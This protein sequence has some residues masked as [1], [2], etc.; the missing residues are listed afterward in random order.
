MKKLLLTF[1]FV[2]LI[3]AVGVS[4]TLGVDN[5]LATAEENTPYTVNYI[6][7]EEDFMDFIK[8]GRYTANKYILTSDIYL[9]RLYAEGGKLGTTASG[10]DLL[11]FEGNFDGRGHAIVGLKEPLFDT[12]GEEGV[13]NDLLLIGVE[14][15][16]GS[17]LSTNP[18]YALAYLNKGTIKYVHMTG[19]V[20]YSA[21]VGT[22]NGTI[23]NSLAVIKRTNMVA[24]KE[25]ML[26]AYE[27][28]GTID[29][30]YSYAYDVSNDKEWG[31]RSYFI[32]AGLVD[33]VVINQALVCDE[34]IMLNDGVNLFNTPFVVPETMNNA[35]IGNKLAGYI[36]TTF[37]ICYYNADYLPYE[38]NIPYNLYD[39]NNG[40]YNTPGTF[41]GDGTKENPYEIGTIDGL[42]TL[43][44]LNEGEYAMLVE[45]IILD[46]VYLDGDN[47]YLIEELN[48][49]LDG[50]GH[51]ITMGN[52]KNKSGTN[53]KLFDNINSTGTVT[54]LFMTGYL[55]T[56][57]MGTITN[58]TGVSVIGFEYG[59]VFKAFIA[60]NEG[61]I[62]RS[63]A[64]GFAG[65]V[66]NNTL[67][68]Q[69]IY[70]S[71][72]NNLFVCNN[73]GP[74]YGGYYEMTEDNPSIYSLLENKTFNLP[75]ATEC[76][77]VNRVDPLN[78]VYCYTSDIDLLTFPDVTTNGEE[79]LY[80]EP[81]AF[82]MKTESDLE[83]YSWGYLNN[84]TADIP[85]LVKPENRL[86]Y[87]KNMRF[88]EGYVEEKDYAYGKINGR[89]NYTLRTLPAGTD[90]TSYTPF[91]EINDNLFVGANGQV[92]ELLTTASGNFTISSAEY[93]I[94]SALSVDAKNYLSTIDLEW[95]YRAIGGEYSTFTGTTFDGATNPNTEYYLY[96][97]DDLVYLEALVTLTDTLTIDYSYVEFGV[98]VNTIIS[99]LDLR[100][101]LASICNDLGY[102]QSQ[103]AIL[104]YEGVTFNIYNAD[105]TP[106]NI[107][108]NILGVNGVE[109]FKIVVTLPSTATVKGSTLTTYFNVVE[110]TID[111]TP[112]ALVSAIGGLEEETAP[113]YDGSV[114][115]VEEA[116]SLKNFSLGSVSD[117]EIINLTR[118]NGLTYV[119]ISDV[120]DAGIYTIRVTIKV[121]GFSD[122]SREF[123]FYV[124]R[125]DVTLYAQVD[126]KDNLTLNYYDALPAV[127][128]HALE[129]EIGEDLVGLSYNTT[130]SRGSAITSGEEY[131]TLTFIAPG[132]DTLNPNYIINSAGRVVTI[133]V[134]PVKITT[135]GAVFPDQEEIFNGTAYSLTF[136]E[137]NILKNTA[138][139]NPLDYT[140]YYEYEGLNDNVSLEFINVGTYTIKAKVVSNT[141]N[142]LD[143]DE[144]EAT[145]TIN[146]N[147]TTIKAFPSYVN[148]GED[149]EYSILVTHTEY[150]SKI[151]LKK[152]LVAGTHYTINSSYVKGES[153]AGDNVE[154]SI[155][156]IAYDD[157]VAG[158]L[159]NYD[160]TWDTTPA[161]L[162]IG[163]K[164]YKLDM[165]TSYPYTGKGVELDFKGEEVTFSDGY[166]VFKRM[167]GGVEYDFDGTPANAIDPATTIYVVY[168][169]IDESNEYYGTDVV[170]K[171]FVINKQTISLSGLY[172]YHNSL[173]YLLEDNLSFLYDK[174]DY[175][176]K[177]DESE[178]SA[179]QGATVTYRYKLY[180]NAG[181]TYDYENSA[182]IT[183]NN[184]TRIKEIS[185][186]I[187]GE[188]YEN[189]TYSN[190]INSFEIAPRE[191]AL[192]PLEGLS[193][194]GYDYPVKP[195]IEDR[196]NALS[197]E[198]GYAPLEGDEVTFSVSLLNGKEAIRDPGNYALVVVSLN[199]NYVIKEGHEL[200][201]R[202][203]TGNA[204]L[205]LY[206]Y[207]FSEY[208]FGVLNATE[209][210]VI[211]KDF[212]FFVDN[213]E[214]LKQDV[215]FFIDYN[216]T[217]QTGALAPGSYNITS[218][219][220]MTG[221]VNGEVKEFIAFNVENG[222]NK[223]VIK[224][225]EIA[226]DYANMISAGVG[227]KSSYIYGDEALK[228]LP[229]R[230]NKTMT[231][232]LSG[233][234][235]TNNP[236]ISV[237]ANKTVKHAGEYT[238]TANAN[239]T[240]LNDNGEEVKAFVLAESVRTYQ[241][242]VEKREILIEVAPLEIFVGDPA[243]AQANYVVTYP[244]P[245]KEPVGTDKLLLAYNFTI[246]N[247]TSETEGE[248]SVNVTAK[249][250]EG[251]QY[252]EDYIIT[253]LDPTA[254][255]LKVKFLEFDASLTASNVKATYTGSEILPTLTGVPQEAT[256]TY[257]LSP[258]NAGT[259]NVT[260]TVE[261][262][263][264]RPAI[265]ECVVTI[266]PAN[267][268][269]IFT[270]NKSFPFDIRHTLTS[271][272]VL[273]YAHLNNVKVEGEFFFMKTDGL[274]DTEFL[275]YGE[276]E[277]VI[278][279][280]PASANFNGVGGIRYKMTT[281]VESSD[282]T[283][284][285][286]GEAF[287]TTYSATDNVTLALTTSERVAGVMHLLVNGTN[288]F[289][290][291]HSNTYVFE[292]SES[293]VLIDIKIR[294]VS[295]YTVELDVN[296]ER[297]TITP[298]N[299]EGGDT[300]GTPETPDTPEGGNSGS[301]SN[302]DQNQGGNSGGVGDSEVAP[303]SGDEEEKGD[304]LGLI[305]ALSVGGGVLLIAG[306]VVLIIFLTKKKGV[307][308]G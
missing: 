1:I 52:F 119:G 163:K 139:P 223:I 86:A 116:L 265:F 167:T 117:L 107:G 75:N 224:P 58:V 214:T 306:V 178:F 230:V 66:G 24:G 46:N 94:K 99:T 111:T 85:I 100:N 30:Q 54:D 283:L 262:A 263:K 56:N 237:T 19:E 97:K 285:L 183:L 271:E 89:E 135:I 231:Y 208:E 203:D 254:K 22:N 15:K 288:T 186:V 72:K 199:P 11:A 129:G 267:P 248:F 69:M 275:R 296:I 136:K 291:A 242:V 184:A 132:D 257:S 95:K 37:T 261:M 266:T 151:D 250:N 137:S 300:P 41:S 101:Q 260:V 219:E 195:F 98:G 87:K 180:N 126:G 209:A 191:I 189:W 246:D 276:Y 7:T 65:L 193:Y 188:N 289:M 44:T 225:L 158:V 39:A 297:E 222:G 281:Y 210:Y 77:G 28:N 115:S 73:N 170:R 269:I 71:S 32:D 148:Y 190:T 59:D 175:V 49:H 159:V 62:I 93:M 110:G 169:K 171:E 9:D 18:K 133:K 207:T 153:M 138:D 67:D 280:N 298:E 60:F 26:F 185:L 240:T 272:D 76:V 204:R 12:I 211:A 268:E 78:P 38:I 140:M 113:V 294:N 27:N 245:S 304:N 226:F 177:Y 258:I 179:T 149:A 181:E 130:Y 122:T 143:S 202:I 264:Y 253:K 131:Y 235:F 290:G 205:D 270:G 92:Y 166:P 104:G 277:Y 234:E 305:I 293:S 182:P 156:P 286:N 192:V 217:Y 247:F 256:V 150:P 187:E 141:P 206:E 81:W 121:E 114:L 20:E 255:E 47:E 160:I 165:A 146:P 252:Y 216:A 233:I 50:N 34:S 51:T 8:T 91:D 74:I 154:F 2:L 45:N 127:T 220:S 218:A 295:V 155:S 174:Y 3:V 123:N 83:V 197:Y 198:T 61:T 57:N 303:D 134:N 282:Y 200:A 128:Y 299:P 168:I 244:S 176:I 43:A 35:T 251:G 292:E 273:G 164:T 25:T 284:T 232:S 162:T 142:Y 82:G 88:Q 33:Y 145:L 118:A 105:G 259:H 125:K 241:M 201:Q 221:I 227:I 10:D 302:T 103:S 23:Q 14:G 17:T 112:Y 308:N 64:E 21:F 287:T 5:T 90:T 236:E 102:T 53:V 212:E 96:Y 215:K 196:V 70:C 106:A 68:G 278:G 238:F 213:T 31:R 42:M 301:G 173:R 161:T 194:K 80:T 172:V 79:Y 157:S 6:E 152:V 307:K 120:K 243:P 4:T 13:I 239:F 48:G 144:V 249:I 109:K 55:A 63:H 84:N 40:V 124:S 16:E 147:K 274:T 108:N 36:N 228:T 229:Q 29:E 279:F